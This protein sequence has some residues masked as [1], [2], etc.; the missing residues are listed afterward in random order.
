MKP[1]GMGELANTSNDPVVETTYGRLRYIIKE[2]TESTLILQQEQ[3]ERWSNQ[4]E[5]R[6]W[7]SVPVESAE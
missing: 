2:G 3:I 1:K 7:I 6:K 4:K 5:T